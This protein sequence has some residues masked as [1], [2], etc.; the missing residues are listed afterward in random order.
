MFQKFISKKGTSFILAPCSMTV[1]ELIGFLEQYR[2][3]QFFMGAA[4]DLAFIATDTGISCESFDYL[5]EWAQE[6]SQHLEEIIR[7]FFYSDDEIG[8][9]EEW[10]N[11]YEYNDYD[12]E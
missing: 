1:D 7:D 4:E 12:D 3:L 10:R 5:C 2:G 9:E 11:R 6:E 8:T